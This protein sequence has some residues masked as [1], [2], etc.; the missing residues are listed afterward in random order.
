VPLIGLIGVLPGIGFAWF[1]GR[2]ERRNFR[3]TDGFRPKL[4]RQF[5]RS[6]AWGFPLVVVAIGVINYSALAAWGINGQ[7]L[8]TACL[9]LALALIAA[10]SLTIHRNAFQI[11]MFAYCMIIAVGISALALGWIP[12]S[13]AQ[14]PMLTATL[15]FFLFFK[16][17]P[18][19]MD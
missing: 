12:Q 19:R 10:R 4:H 15:L 18:V 16:K 14:L 11:A 5:F 8:F 3:D 1:V 2:M 13:M 6:F 7:Q 9:L 17:R